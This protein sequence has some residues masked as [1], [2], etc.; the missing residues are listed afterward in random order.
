MRVLLVGGPFHWRTLEPPAKVPEILLV[1]PET[2]TMRS[3]L[4]PYEPVDAMLH[5]ARYVPCGGLTHRGEVV[6]EVYEYME[7][8]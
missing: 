6:G 8:R 3:T 7:T 1:E 2:V 5:V 4:D